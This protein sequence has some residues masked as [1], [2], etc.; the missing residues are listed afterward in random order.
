[1]R[2]S[3]VGLVGAVLVECLLACGGG[4]APARA[5]WK[6]YL[7]TDAPVPQL[8]QQV[9]VELIDDQGRPVSP[10]LRRLLD[11][12]RPELWP[13]SFGIVPAGGS[14]PRMRARFYRLDET[15]SDGLPDAAT[16]VDATA[17][18]PSPVDGV[19]QTALRLSMNCFGVGPD[20]AGHRTCDPSTGRLGPE[21]TLPSGADP[22]SLPSVG[23]WPPAVP[24]ACSGSAPHGMVCAPGGAFLLGSTQFFPL[25]EEDPVPEHLVQLAPFWIDADEVSV[26]DIRPLVQAGKLPRPL[27][28]D[29]AGYTPPECTYLS[30]TDSTNDAYPVNCV[31]WADANLACQLLGKRLPTE[32]EWEYVAD[33]LGAK[34]PFPWGA[35]TDICHYAVVA[36]GRGLVGEEIECLTGAP[37]PHPHDGT[38][39]DVVATDVPSLGGHVRNMAGNVDEFVA[40]VFD[41]YSGPC[42]EQGKTLLVN[43]LCTASVAKT[44]MHTIRGGAWQLPS[45]SAY[46]YVRDSST[47]DG[48]AVA[49]G[50]RCAKSM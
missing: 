48:P 25:G 32:A 2:W 46:S 23:T 38:G 43:P 1:V 4:T 42:W 34:L 41:P 22:S 26:G 7:A 13:I 19:T 31:S 18:L 14:P 21:P 37:G 8:G 24:V 27:V 47:L 44:S 5:Q 3:S 35:D 11:G 30:D 15:G 36:S 17:V 33:G 20:L 29:P 9:L 40:D 28:G 10:T 49:T 50:F 39:L 16:I 6:V 45:L 12:S